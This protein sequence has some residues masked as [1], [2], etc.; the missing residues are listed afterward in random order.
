MCLFFNQVCFKTSA[1]KR[2]YFF[3]AV[4]DAISKV[5]PLVIAQRANDQ[6]ERQIARARLQLELL[7]II[8]DQR[9]SARVITS[10]STE[11]KFYSL[12]LALQKW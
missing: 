8:K 12:D 6:W 1:V 11:P 4:D 3:F 9:E 2:E 10:S 5:L 7:N